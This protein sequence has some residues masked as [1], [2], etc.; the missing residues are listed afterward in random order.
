MLLV[1]KIVI[2]I[3]AGWKGGVVS[4]VGVRTSLGL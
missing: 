1:I 3:I 4:T 2:P